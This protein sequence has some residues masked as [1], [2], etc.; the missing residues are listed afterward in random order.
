MTG[1][2][3]HAAGYVEKRRGVC[4]WRHE[5]EDVVLTCDSPDIPGTGWCLKHLMAADTVTF[6]ARVITPPT[7]GATT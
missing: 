5:W 3:A 4:T 6:H 7:T 1:T 2:H